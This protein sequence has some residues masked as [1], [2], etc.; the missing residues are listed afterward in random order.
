M[1]T[2]RTLRAVKADAE[3]ESRHY[4]WG[5]IGR[6]FT[7]T[8]TADDTGSCYYHNADWKAIADESVRIITELGQR[9]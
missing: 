3:K 2:F 8:I 9:G 1:Q 5:R 4:D 6:A 7:D